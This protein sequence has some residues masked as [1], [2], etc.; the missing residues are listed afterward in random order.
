MV[1]ALRT[2]LG[3]SDQSGGELLL[4]G[5]GSGIGDGER[6]STGIQFRPGGTVHQSGLYGSAVGR[7]DQD[8]HGRKGAGAGQHIRGKA[9]AKRQAR[10]GVYQRLPERGRSGE[11][12]R[13]ILRLLQ[14]PAV[15]PVVIVSDTGSGLLAGSDMKQFEVDCN[16][17]WVA[18]ARFDSTHLFQSVLY[19][20]LPQNLS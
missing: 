11:W 17:R 2:L 16:L 12:V 8:Q 9:M 18:A 7:R 20:N 14:S 10:G 1:L 3:G 5:V 19:L 15:A 6:P 4:G 13:A